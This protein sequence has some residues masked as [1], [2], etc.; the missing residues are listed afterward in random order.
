MKAA[1]LHWEFMFAR[2]M[3]KTPDM[4]KQHELLDFIADS[5][6]DGSIKTTINEVISPIN[7]ANLKH[8]HGLIERGDAIGKVV[9]A[10]WP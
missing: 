7:A 6:D 1:S 5:I 3:F 10:D 8:A 9:L 4:I 2:S